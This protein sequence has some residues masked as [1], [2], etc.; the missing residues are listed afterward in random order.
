M[1]E[2]G[3][4][5]IDD[6]FYTIRNDV[7]VYTSWE[8][9][10]LTFYRIIWGT[11]WIIIARLVSCVCQFIYFIMDKYHS[12][13]WIRSMNF[14]TSNIGEIEVSIFVWM[15]PIYSNFSRCEVSWSEGRVDTQDPEYCKG[16]LTQHN[17]WMFMVQLGKIRVYLL[18]VNVWVLDISHGQ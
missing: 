13:S 6:S 12:K 9:Y 17:V 7:L 4:P 10:G 8:S 3:A 15:L 11:K 18:W 14:K 5:G 2:K 16:S 1:L